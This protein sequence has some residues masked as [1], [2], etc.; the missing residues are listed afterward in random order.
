[1]ARPDSQVCGVGQAKVRGIDVGKMWSAKAFLIR[2]LSCIPSFVGHS[3]FLVESIDVRT[4]IVIDQYEI[5]KTARVCR[6]VEH[7]HAILDGY[8]GR[9]NSNG[10]L[11]D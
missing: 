1:M 11:S 2:R 10:F 3:V 7:Q 6:E 9:P 8:L 5:V 4:L